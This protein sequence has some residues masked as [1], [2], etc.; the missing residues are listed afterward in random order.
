MIIYQN[1][2]ESLIEVS[3]DNEGLTRL[4]KNNKY[5]KLKVQLNAV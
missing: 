5:A 3:D 4:F 2:F 1:A